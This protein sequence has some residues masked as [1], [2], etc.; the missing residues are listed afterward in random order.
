MK[1]IF[2]LLFILCLLLTTACAPAPPVTDDPPQPD[3]N[4]DHAVGTV[5]PDD[6]PK[7]PEPEPIPE[8]APDPEPEPARPV[9]QRRSAYI[10]HGE[11]D[12]AVDSQGNVILEAKADSLSL[13][14][15][16]TTGEIACI[17]EFLYEGITTDQWGWAEPERSWCRLYDLQG[18]LLLE[19]E[20]PYVSISGGLVS[21]Y[22]TKSSTYTVLR[23]SDGGI[24]VEQA[25]MAWLADNVIIVKDIRWEQPSTVLDAN[26]KV[27]W[28]QADGWYISGYQ[29]HGQSFYLQVVNPDGLTGLAS[30]HGDMLLPCEYVEIGDITGNL[31]AVSNGSQWFVVDL[32]TGET[33]LQWPTRIIALLDSSLIVQESGDYGRNILIDYNGQRLSDR[34]FQWLNPVDDNFDDIPELLYGNLDQS[35]STLP[36]GVDIFHQTVVFLRPDG[37]EI[38]CEEYT[39]SQLEP[40]DSRTVLRR[41]EEWGSED[42]E[43]AVQNL[44]TGEIT[45]I[46]IDNIVFTELLWYYSSD[47]PMERQYFTAYYENQLGHSRTCVVDQSG[48]ILLDDLKGCIYLGGGVFQVAVGFELGLMDLN[49]D[50][51]FRQSQFTGLRD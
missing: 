26:G 15:D 45:D 14:Q 8:P 49:G 12:V 16:S 17:Q 38:F 41:D 47:D 50:W 25:G 30:P 28:Q 35:Q 22:D 37:T 48:T 36:D 46:P 4:P 2:C 40:M 19:P 20:A 3:S 43:Y 33:L 24:V 44:E 11:T 39:T 21:C 1:R 18:N 42:T 27:L 6:P 31:A 13:L 10:F 34:V 32:Q 9:P 51:L 7:D 23:L 29:Q 5:V